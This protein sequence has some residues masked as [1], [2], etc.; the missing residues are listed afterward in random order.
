MKHGCSWC[1]EPSHVLANCP[2][3]AALNVV[4]EHG[5]IDPMATEELND[6]VALRMM[7]YRTYAGQLTRLLREAGLAIP[8][9]VEA[10]N[11]DHA[12][13]S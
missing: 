3:A 12:Y 1:L 11:P 6:A 4:R 7:A 9:D 8:A 5:I 13:Q 2:K 10:L